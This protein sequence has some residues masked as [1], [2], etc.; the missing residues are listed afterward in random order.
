M[1]KENL[2]MTSYIIGYRAGNIIGQRQVIIQDGFTCA[3]DGEGNITIT[4][5]EAENDG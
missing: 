3:D 1:N 4:E 5:Q 2:D